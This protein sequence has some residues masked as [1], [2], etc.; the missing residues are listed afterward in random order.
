MTPLTAPPLERCH[1][2]CRSPPSWRATRTWRRRRRGAARGGKAVGKRC[3][4]TLQLLPF[5]LPGSGRHRGDI[6]NSG[7]SGGSLLSSCL[8]GLLGTLLD[9]LL[10]TRQKALGLLGIL[11]DKLLDTRH[12]ALGLL[13]TRLGLLSTILDKLLPE[14]L[15]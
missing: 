14:V 12:K 8:V 15:Y 13:G 3:S 6:C 7:A 2:R 10:D 1:D 9:N 5:L 11:L 4:T